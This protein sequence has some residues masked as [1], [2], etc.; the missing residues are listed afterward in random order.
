MN[1][2]LTFHTLGGLLLSLAAVLLAPIPF[3]IV[4]GDGTTWAYLL[5]AVITGG[6]GALLYLT[7]ATKA[8]IG[9]REGFAIVTLGWLSFVIF[10]GLPYLL[11]G[12]FQHPIDAVF[13]SASGF[14]TTGATVIS[15]LSEL[16]K[17]LLLW[18]SLTQ[19][20]GGMGIIVLTI[21][22][23]P[24]LNVGGMQMFRA[25]VPGPTKDRFT[26]RIQDTARV[27]WEVY[28]GLTVIEIMM[29]GMGEM[30]W[31]EALC[32]GMT[33]MATGGFS[34]LDASIA[35]FSSSYTHWVIT[36]FMFLAGVNFS[37]HYAILI[38]G[39]RELFRSEEFRVYTGII[40]LAIAAIVVSIWSRYDNGGL[41]LRDA[42]FQVVS[43]MT[44]T[45][46]GSADF[47]QW[48][49]ATQVILMGLMIVGA[50]S[51]STGGGIKVVRLMIVLK[52]AHQQVFFLF[53]PRGV[54]MVKVDHRQIPDDVVQSVLGFGALYFL[55]FALATFLQSLVDVD[56]MTAATGTISSLS[57][58]GPGFG[59]IGPTENYSHL[60]D[61]AKWV[62]TA[63]ML[64]GRLELFTVLVLFVPSFWR[65]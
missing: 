23:L 65:R 4:F 60:P 29:L 59:S 37:L 64:M 11:L 14:T 31:F 18:R 49:L 45:G 54:R 46:F 36:I 7:L 24:M 42:A 20:L 48:P 30:T 9:A 26:P 6:C 13:E 21:A 2:R 52:H 62:L 3:A 40:V 33:T 61:T 15:N 1:T 58:I 39:P 8:E 28:F 34:T 27:L 57:N 17:S 19:W 47:E 35:G 32:H 38:R 51:G 44:S 43:M 55:I 25:E 12:V 50:M 22:I 63:C 16:P 53:H 56:L 10:G 41:A 5:T